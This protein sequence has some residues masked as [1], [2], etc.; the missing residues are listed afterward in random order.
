MS[1]SKSSVGKEQNK[2]KS[3]NLAKNTLKENKV[4]EKSNQ[5][6]FL[7]VGENHNYTSCREFV[8][9]IC[10]NKSIKVKN[11]FVEI[12]QEDYDRVKNTV[13]NGVA[14]TTLRDGLIQDLYKIGQDFDNS[15][16]FTGIDISFSNALKD[17]ATINNVNFAS[18][19]V[20]AKENKE[21]VENAIKSAV[22]ADNSS[23]KWC[24]QE[25]VD[26]YKALLKSRGDNRKTW[27]H[28]LADCYESDD[29]YKDLVTAML[30]EDKEKLDENPN[31]DKGLLGSLF[32]KATT[33]REHHMLQTIT[34]V[35]PVEDKREGINIIL[36]GKDHVA[37][38][39]KN[40]EEKYDNVNIQTVMQN[41]IKKNKYDMQ[42]DEKN[43]LPDFTE[44]DNI[45][46]ETDTVL[47]CYK[48]HELYAENEEF[49]NQVDTAIDEQDKVKLAEK[50]LDDALTEAKRLIKAS[51]FKKLDSPKEL[52]SAVISTIF[53][54]EELASSLSQSNDFNSEQMGGFD[55]HSEETD[56]LPTM[57]MQTYLLTQMNAENN[58]D[59][60]QQT[61][62]NS[63]TQN[64]V[65]TISPNNNQNN[66]A[67]Q[68]NDNV[69]LE[70]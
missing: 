63:G 12:M 62:A 26:V 46:D 28:K 18:L 3:N 4:E 51:K 16:E 7:I 40:L 23:K 25:I 47:F 14:P 60:D 29:E 58:S 24:K 66:T 44:D 57:D 56:V 49:K 10:K 53:D 5:E 41:Q 17:F 6:T 68:K 39:S 65:L 15:A 27:C 67:D 50:K 69:D 11:L 45:F 19:Q 54:D 2:T 38:I 9:K 48:S 61:T 22:D 33:Y 35:L 55:L 20:K 42:Q 64:I 8:K 37:G 1:M 32:D 59:S 36:I 34:T 70:N 21:D 52:Y 13:D 43:G 30:I 31:Y